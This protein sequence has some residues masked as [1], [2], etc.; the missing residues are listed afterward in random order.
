MQI[1]K[2][3]F[4]LQSDLSLAVCTCSNV[5]FILFWLLQ[6]EVQEDDIDKS[7]WGELESESES[8]EES[9]EESEPEA[10]ETGLV[11]PAEG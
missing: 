3:L 2:T 4:R 6:K 5:L 10:D 7:H 8:E 1:G 9:S 11:T